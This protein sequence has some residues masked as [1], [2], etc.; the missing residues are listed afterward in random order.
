MKYIQPIVS[1]KIKTTPKK[2]G[3][4]LNRYFKE[5]EK[6]KGSGKHMGGKKLNLMGNQGMQIENM[7][8]FRYISF[9]HWPTI[10]KVKVYRRLLN[11]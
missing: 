7:I 8:S 4:M 11:I 3:S 5:V 10:Q 9:T 2:N 1:R 6:K